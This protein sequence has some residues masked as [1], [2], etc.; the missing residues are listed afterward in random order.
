M[1]KKISLREAVTLYLL[2]TVSPTIMASTNYAAQQAN[3]AAWLTPLAA[4]LPGLLLVWM[5]N[6][7]FQ[8]YPSS[9]F[10]EMLYDICGVWAGKIILILYGIWFLVLSA[11]YLRFYAERIQSSLLTE[12]GIDFLLIVM[13][14]LI[15]FSLR[16]GLKTVSGFADLTLPV[17]LFLLAFLVVF[18][19][20]KMRI[21]ELYPVTYLDAV[22]VLRG[23]LAPISVTGYLICLLFLGNKIK[24]KSQMKKQGT[25]GVLLLAGISVL[26]IGI[27]V[28]TCGVSVTKRSPIPFFLAV[29][30]IQILGILERF[31]PILIGVWIISDFLL[32]F[33]FIYC[34]L[35]ISKS[36]CHL[37]SSRILVLP[38]LLLLLPLTKI[39]AS[40]RF[41]LELFTKNVVG[42]V[43]MVF[44]YIIPA[45]VILL[46][47]MRKKC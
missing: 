40:S 13:F 41:E 23:G 6:K 9:S 30:Q 34:F 2:I 31:E 39:I 29:K 32:I 25:I 12:T 14:V 15:W 5:M 26:I 21:Q 35:D 20:P 16:K 11:V 27:S 44:K 28:G 3:Q 43:G 37:Q 46:G 1:E 24:N 8:K 36:V 47:K 18:A 19:L 22:P 17:I 38:L 42:A 10:D 4:V 7:L 45:G 33:L